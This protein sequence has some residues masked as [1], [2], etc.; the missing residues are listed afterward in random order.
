MIINWTI[1]RFGLFGVAPQIPNMPILNYVGVGLTVISIFTFI[2]VKTEEIHV[3]NSRYM[4]QPNFIE[5]KP[6]LDAESRIH[7][8]FLSINNDSLNTSFEQE[9]KTKSKLDKFMYTFTDKNKKIL[10]II[11]SIFCGL[12]SGLSYLPIMYTQNNYP[13][14]SQDYNDYYFSY[15]CGILIMSVIVFALYCI[16]EGNNP[17]VDKEVV[18]PGLL[19]GKNNFWIFLRK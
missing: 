1:A 17:S 4:P 19:V 15:T 3:M 7:T 8:D 16:F 11:L 2:F 10:A 13:N 14:A 6:L 18:M 9:I 5:R 12:M